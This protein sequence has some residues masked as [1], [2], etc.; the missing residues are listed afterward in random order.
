MQLALPQ[1]A[2]CL[3]GASAGRAPC[4]HQG[5]IA[6]STELRSSQ[7]V[8]Q[9]QSEVLFLS[10]QQSLVPP[11]VS[12]RCLVAPCWRRAKASSGELEHQTQSLYELLCT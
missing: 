5:E 6:Q 2:D 11:Q 9:R 1:H 4:V 3:G 10:D 7:Q 8:C 12:S